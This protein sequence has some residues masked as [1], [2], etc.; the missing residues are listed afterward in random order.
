MRA[1]R[2]GVTAALSLALLVASPAG[3]GAS[4]THWIPPRQLP[5]YWQLTGAVNNSYA[6]AAYDI[7]GFDNSASEVSA[8]HA[9]GKRA[10]CYIN[11]GTWENWRSDAGSFPQSVLGSSNGWPGEKWLD[12]SKLSVLRPIMTARLQMCA[13]K[14]FDAVEPDN[15]DGYQ[16]STGFPLTAQDQL[17]YNEWIA[18]EAHA[19]GL[20]VFQKNDPDQSSALQPYFDG[21]LD[22]QCNQ[23]SECSSFQPYVTANKPV[24]NAEYSSS[25]Y[26]GFCTSD[27][28]TGIMGALYSLSLNGSTYK[29]CF[30]LNATTAPIPPTGTPP[31][32]GP[33]RPH[34]KRPPKTHALPTGGG[35]TVG[36]S[37]KELTD[38][39]STVAVRLSCLDGRSYCDG[40]VKLAVLKSGRH[41]VI[42]GKSR[43]RIARVRS[44][45][46]VIKLSTRA[47][48]RLRHA[49]SVRAVI[50]VSARDR[51]G[52]KGSSRRVVTLHL[53][54]HRKHVHP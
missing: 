14:S 19:L 10:I 47:L 8:L 52:H 21:A 16:N 45:V 1:R 20:A 51:A 34:K 36:I 39:R 53:P 40:T 37:A 18:G 17:N 33:S 27:N 42:F 48:S 13:Q 15:I 43:F 11:A 49:R 44:A 41:K 29:P 23:Y 26:P 6:A 4:P 32:T 22:E 12:I 7:D 46:V 28:S 38:T 30:S 5:W 54:R 35:P 9:T 25:L 24:L 2:T 3:A 50:E 31:P